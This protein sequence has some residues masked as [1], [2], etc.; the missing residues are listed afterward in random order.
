MQ[1]LLAGVTWRP[2]LSLLESATKL[3]GRV[4]QFALLPAQPG[5]GW[6]TGR[7]GVGVTERGAARPDGRRAAA[8]RTAGRAPQ[9]TRGPAPPPSPSPA[10]VRA[11]L[12]RPRGT[13]KRPR[14]RP[15]CVRC[16]HRL[17]LT[18]DLGQI[19]GRPRFRPT[20]TNPSRSTH[21]G[22]T[23]KQHPHR[24]ASAVL[25]HQ[26]PSASTAGAPAPAACSSTACSSWRV[27]P[28]CPTVGVEARAPTGIPGRR[29]ARAVPAEPTT[30]SA[31]GPCLTEP[32]LSPVVSFPRRIFTSASVQTGFDAGDQP[33]RGR[34][35]RTASGSPGISESAA[36]TVGCSATGAGAR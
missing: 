14:R 19:S 29:R 24:I 36:S 30:A 21:R 28:A 18:A 5:G 25:R 6:R 15:Q 13:R 8:R 26:P 31:E 10:A 12:T 9:P 16:V 7:R 4:K 11:C 27:A 23:P 1:L 20:R 32:R 33:D 22:C 2:S 34:C 35:T 17:L 3:E